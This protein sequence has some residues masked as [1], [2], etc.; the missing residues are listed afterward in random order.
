MVFTQSA[1]FYDDFYGH[2]DYADEVQRLRAVVRDRAP[3]ARRWLDVACGTGRHLELLA[4]HFE[5]AGVDLD[6]TLLAKARTRCPGV[7]LTV[8]DMRSFALDRRFDVVS[9]LFSSIGYART[10]E[11]LHAT[12]ANLARHLAEGGV[13]IVEPW[14]EPGEWETGRVAAERPIEGG[15]RSLVRM[16]ASGREGNVSHLDIHYL[17]GVDGDVTYGHEHHELG[18]FPWDEYR[19]AFE[20][21]G[22]VGVEIDPA[23]LIGRGLVIG[24]APGP[25]QA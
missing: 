2:K 22:L 8:G 12:V 18:L 24:V 6:P 10:V 4:R 5:V 14:F 21:A 1:E 9:C 11:G 20:A 16:F 3:G 23:G 15:R 17:V 7:E 19:S 25:E 13:L